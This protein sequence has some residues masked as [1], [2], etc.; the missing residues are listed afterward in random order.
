MAMKKKLL[1]VTVVVLLGGSMLTRAATIFE[2]D[3]SKI[4]L[5]GRLSVDFLVEET[6]QYTG[7][8][9]NGSRLGLRGYHN[10]NQSLS[11]YGRFEARFDGSLRTG[12]FSPRNT[13]FG[14]KGDFGD[15]RFGEFESVFDDHVSGISDIGLS[16]VWNYYSLGDTHDGG[17]NLGYYNTIGG[18]SFAIMLKHQ[19]KDEA[20]G[21][22]QAVNFQ[23]GASIPLNDKIVLGIAANQDDNN[24]GQGNPI[25]GAGIRMALVEGLNWGIILEGQNNNATVLGTV[26]RY[27]LASQ[28]LAGANVY[29]YVGGANRSGNPNEMQFSLGSSYRVTSGFRTY[30]E[31]NHRIISSGSNNTTDF[32][33]GC[34]FDF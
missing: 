5:Y 16:N 15:F 11:A 14:V 23:A 22:D 18:V 13:Y 32:A 24:F 27:D 17:R 34:R 29:G 20:A 25:F 1:I 19:E 30:G 26:V 2:D 9:N 33:V 31:V 7:L 12:D 3:Q 4:D 8:R 21:T 28:G 10:L 6:P